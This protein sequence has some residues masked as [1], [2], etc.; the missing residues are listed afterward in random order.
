MIDTWNSSP[1]FLKYT[2]NSFKNQFYKI[3]KKYMAQ[4]P[5]EAL[6]ARQPGNR[7]K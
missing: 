6:A 3:R 4:R 5:T 7:G 2:E 1:K